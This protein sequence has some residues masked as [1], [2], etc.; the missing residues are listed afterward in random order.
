[1][2]KDEGFAVGEVRGDVLGVQV[3]LVL[4]GGEDDDDV[5]PLGGFGGG[6]NTESR[7]FSFLG[8]L[9]AGL[10]RHDHLNA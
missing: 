7:F 4:V 2:T 10:E 1:V 5:S 6:E 8:G 3:A 9:G